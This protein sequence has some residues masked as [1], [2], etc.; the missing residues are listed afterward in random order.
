MRCAGGYHISCSAHQAEAESLEQGSHSP[1]VHQAQNQPGTEAPLAQFARP[2]GNN[3]CQTEGSAQ[4]S[5]EH[6]A[7]SGKHDKPG[8][9]EQI[10]ASTAQRLLGY[11]Y[12]ALQ[13]KVAWNKGK[14]MSLETREK[15]S[16]AKQGRHTP[17]S[18]RRKMSK[19]HQGLTHTP[20]RPSW[21]ACTQPMLPCMQHETCAAWSCLTPASK[22]TRAC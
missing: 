3:L 15:M 12:G 17:R 8:D 4:N 21:T 22:C 5:L 6:F 11:K 2:E 19:S 14:K 1:R 9:G 7:A 18:V 10:K 16:L 13:G 20:V